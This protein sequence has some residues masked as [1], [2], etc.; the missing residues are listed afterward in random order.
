MDYI[1]NIPRYIEAGKTYIYENPVFQSADVYIYKGSIRHTETLFFGMPQQNYISSMGCT[2]SYDGSYKIILQNEGSTAI[3]LGEIVYHDVPGRFT[4]LNNLNQS[5]YEKLYVASNLNLV[6]YNSNNIAPVINN[7]TYPHVHLNATSVAD[8]IDE[9]D[10]R[11][12][13]CGRTFSELEFG[14]V[15][16]I[17]ILDD[18]GNQITMDNYVIGSIIYRPN[19]QA[20]YM[21]LY[22]FNGGNNNSEQLR[23]IILKSIDGISWTKFADY[24]DYLLIDM[25]CNESLVCVAG[26]HL[27][28]N[29]VYSVGIWGNNLENPISGWE[30]VN[31]MSVANFNYSKLK[32]LHVSLDMDANSI[33]FLINFAG[34]INIYICKLTTDT[35]EAPWWTSYELLYRSS[36]IYYVKNIRMGQYCI[37]TDYGHASL[38]SARNAPALFCYICNNG[39]IGVPL[40]SPNETDTYPNIKYINKYF[41]NNNMIYMSLEDF[42]GQSQVYNGII[43]AKAFV[44]PFGKIISTKHISRNAGYT[45]GCPCCVVGQC[46]N[47]DIILTSDRYEYQNIEIKTEDNDFSSSNSVRIK[48][49]ISD[50][51]GFGNNSTLAYGNFYTTQLLDKLYIYSPS[52]YKST[53]VPN[54]NAKLYY[55]QVKM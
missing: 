45:N 12:A 48:K 19:Y 31:D 55:S 2:I 39:V 49:N 43:F 10:D 22:T 18:A 50:T 33:L 28:T 51:I 38:A 17:D 25:K 9:L 41:D 36:C 1:K 32:T 14:A 37:Y 4:Q 3:L 53:L 20:Y 21:L 23:S 5:S 6:N 54:G 27:I 42:E 11:I 15:K 46:G 7:R 40:V 44:D 47:I 8:A 16:D 30:K 29:T 26:F 35:T 52:Y 24:A 13:R 34:T